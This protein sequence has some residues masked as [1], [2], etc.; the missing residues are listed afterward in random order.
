MHDWTYM[1]F[2]KEYMEGDAKSQIDDQEKA[3]L[4][5][6]DEDQIW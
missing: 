6:N 1:S 3:K 5:F 4:C 2:I